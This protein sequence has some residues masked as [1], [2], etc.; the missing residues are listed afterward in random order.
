V[1]L[2]E[3]RRSSSPG[4]ELAYAGVSLVSVGLLVYASYV[5]HGG[6][7]EDDWGNALIYH[8]RGYAHMAFDFW[9]HEKPWRPVL[10]LLLPL[11][12][13]LFGLTPSLHLATGLVLAVLASLAFFVFLRQVGIEL[14]HAIAMAVL[15][16]VFPW[17]DALRL[18]STGSLNNL[19]PMTYFLGAAAALHALRLG[20]AQ[21]HPRR[22]LHALSVTLYLVSLF[23]YEIAAP[24]IALS[25]L[26]YRARVPWSALRRRWLL[27]ASIVLLWLMAVVYPSSRLHDVHSLDD[28]SRAVPQTVL[29]ASSLFASMF[30]PRGVS[31][32][33]A[34]LLVLVAVAVVLGAVLRRLRNRDD[35]ELRTWLLRACAG[36][37]AVG[38]GYVMFLGYVYPLA[39]G[40]ENRVNALS[41]YGFVVAA[42]SVVALLC[43][44][45]SR[46]RQPSSSIVLVGGV[47]LLGLGLVDRVLADE[48]RY[49]ASAAQQREQLGTLRRV[50]P[51]VPAHTTVFTFRHLLTSGH[52]VPILDAPWVFKAAAELRWG[53]PTLTVVSAVGRPVSCAR[54][55]ARIAFDVA[56]SDGV[57]AARYGRAEFV[58]L[59]APSVRHV[60]SL[61][62]CREAL[63]AIRARAR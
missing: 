29:Q 59:S 14:P 46:S 21:R 37:C 16:L 3:L 40:P 20:S 15:A 57:Y 24:V 7:Y 30:L 25:G 42:Y 58:D 62:R 33:G 47:L 49:E 52:G 12:H 27:D 32:P 53:D 48:R 39:E 26:L 9:L 5:L 13:A 31:S 51:R 50:L 2:T 43:L 60:D 55:E 6:F 4:R 63:A 36:V 23:T 44:L 8:E 19:A 34:K 35:G 10:A 38:V 56:G 1:R 28:R 17:S 18:W 54:D 11:P 45:V 41:S 61:R 22:A